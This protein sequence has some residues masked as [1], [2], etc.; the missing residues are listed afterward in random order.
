VVAVIGLGG[1]GVAAV[2][3]IGAYIA[4]R[5]MQYQRSNQYAE[6]F[7]EAADDLE[8]DRLSVRMAALLAFQQLADEAPAYG[9]L[10]A[11][12]V[13]AFLREHVSAGLRAPTISAGEIVIAA[14]LV[15]RLS[16][17][18][19]G[20]RSRLDLSGVALPNIRF[21][22]LD[23]SFA[24]FSR[25][26]VGSSSPKQRASSFQRTILSDADLTE[27]TL[28]WSNLWQA[29]LSRASLRGASLRH[30][31]LIRA[32]LR[33]ADCSGTDFSDARFDGADL[34]GAIL[35]DADLSQA[36]GLTARQLATAITDAGTLLPREIVP[37]RAPLGDV[38]RSL[39]RRARAGV[40]I[41]DRA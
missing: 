27:A 40:G 31:V 28:D 18:E 3:L 41:G 16:R 37:A 22:A 2:G 24:R 33:A 38:L 25:A 19:G 9:R 17:A 21:D 11:P 39:V 35:F 8:S 23:L 7:R 5:T 10:I 15:L 6:R 32:R 12:L 26:T 14:E 1:L 4:W 29:D 34:G 36:K 20:L 13:C 30:A